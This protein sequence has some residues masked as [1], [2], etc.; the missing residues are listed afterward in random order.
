MR[1][2]A[3]KTRRADNRAR[4][5]H[6]I[7]ILPYVNTLAAHRS[8]HFQVVIDHQRHP[9]RPRD[10][11]HQPRQPFNLSGQQLLRPQLQHIHPAQAELLRHALDVPRRDITEIHNPIQTCVLNALH[12][13]P[14]HASQP[15]RK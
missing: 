9:M 12:P 5:A 15:Q 6:G 4:H 13:P 8:S 7:V 3:H 10:R 11:Q 1:R 14:V 2:F